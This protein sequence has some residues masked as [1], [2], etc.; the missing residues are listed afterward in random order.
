VT[1]SDAYTYAQTAGNVWA[2]RKTTTTP[3]ATTTPDPT[4]APTSTGTNPRDALVSGTYKPDATNTGVIAGITL[5]PYNTGG[6]VLNITT[7]DTIF[8]NL[9]IYGDLNIQAP[10]VQ[11]INCRLRG[12]TNW[13]TGQ[14]A[15]ADCR[16]ATVLS[17]VTD[18][19]PWDGVPYFEDCTI[20]AQRPSYYRD[21]IDGHAWVKRCNIYNTNDG[22]GSYN[23]DT[24]STTKGSRL[25]VEGS[26]I[27]ELIYWAP[28]PAHADGTHNDLIQLQCGGY[29]HIIGNYLQGTVKLGDDRAYPD[30]DGTAYAGGSLSTD[31]TAKPGTFTQ[32]NGDGVGHIQGA[33]TLIQCN[34]WGGVLMKALDNNVIVEQNWYSNGGMSGNLK[35]GVYV[36][37][38][39]TIRRTAFYYWNGTLSNEYPIRPTSSTT[40]A[41]VTGLYTTNK[42]EDNGE[43]LTVANGGIRY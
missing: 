27:H 1:G 20:Y 29:V 22:I 15:V 34:S 10:G 6:A 19:A 11:F 23:T 35:D 39:N 21:G 36:F 5:T 2:R 33:G 38:N 24:S 30:P 26:W 25:K 40:G 17:R 28:E 3:T 16:S 43:I 42:Y 41:K 37:Q 14:D 32:T 4:P 9:D 31:L 7:A 18:I 12:G 8:A 13:P